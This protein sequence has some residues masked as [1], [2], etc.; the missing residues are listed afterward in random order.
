MRI[1]RGRRIL[2]LWL[3]KQDRGESV[4]YTA[5]LQCGRMAYS[6]HVKKVWACHYH[7]FWLFATSI[8]YGALHFWCPRNVWR[9]V[10]GFRGYTR[11]EVSRSIISILLTTLGRWVPIISKVAYLRLPVCFVDSNFTQR[12]HAS[13]VRRSRC[14]GVSLFRV[15]GMHC[16]DVRIISIELLRYKTILASHYRRNITCRDNIRHRL[17]IGWYTPWHQPNKSPG[18]AGRAQWVA[19]ETL[20]WKIVV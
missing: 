17:T 8:V 6:L 1:C 4:E 14:N 7:K 5:A 9:K 15:I 13:A 16:V 3:S 20:H 12:R 10:A 11:Q 19:S 18:A 2:I